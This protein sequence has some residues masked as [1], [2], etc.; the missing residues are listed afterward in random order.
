MCPW[1]KSTMHTDKPSMWTWPGLEAKRK[2]MT[3]EASCRLSA[4]PNHPSC[5]S[6]DHLRHH[7]AA[8]FHDILKRRFL[9]E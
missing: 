6:R 3:A 1:F 9:T 4:A 5:S 2:T 8:S 7:L